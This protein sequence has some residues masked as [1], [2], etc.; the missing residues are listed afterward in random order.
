MSKKRTRQPDANEELVEGSTDSCDESSITGNKC[1][2]IAKAVN[3]NKIKRL[4]S[5]VG[6]TMECSDCKQNK[7]ISLQINEEEST[8]SS[9]T[10]IC[11]VCG[12]R[13]CK[14]EEYG[15]ALQHFKTPHSDC[16]C[17]VVNTRSWNVW[18]HDCEANIP[19]SHRNKLQETVE[20]IKQAIIVK[21]V[22]SQ[23]N[24]TLSYLW[25]GAV[26]TDVQ[27]EKALHN[28]PKVGGL[29]N[30]GNT[31][32]FNA[33][34]QCLAQTPFLVKVLSDL[35]LPG[36]KIVL[37]GGKHKP[38][39]S[40]EE[41]DITPIEGTLEGWGNFTSVLHATLVE[42]Q[43][44]DGQKCYC[45]SELLN[46]FKKKQMQCMDGGQHDSHELLRHLLELV[47]N[48]DLKRYQLVILKA[49]GLN[50]K[51][52][53]EEV[54]K[55]LKSCVKFYGNQ[56]SARLLGPEP[57]FCG[58]LVSTLECLD[59]H[60]TSQSTEPF[61]DLSLPVMADK[62]QPPIVKR[63]NSG[64][65]DAFDMLGNMISRASTKSQL[66]K[67]KKPA[68]KN[69]RSK[70]QESCDYSNDTS[71]KSNIIEENNGS[72]IEPEE[73]SDADVEDNAETEAFPPEVG[74]SGYSSEKQ[75]TLAS[76]AS[77][78][79]DPVKADETMNEMALDNSLQFSPIN[80]L[81]PNQ[82]FFKTNSLHSPHSTDMNIKDLSQVK[83]RDRLNNC[84]SPVNEAGMQSEYFMSSSLTVN[85][86]LT[87]PEGPSTVSLSSATS[88]ESSCSPTLAFKNASKN[89]MDNY[90][91][92][93]AHN[94]QENT[95]YNQRWGRRNAV[96]YSNEICN[97]VNGISSGISKMGLGC[98][99]SPI[100]Y[101][102]NEGEC[103]IMSCLN[104]FT[105]LE[106]MRGSNK[107]SCEACTARER[108]VKE[109][110]KMICTP[111]TKQYLISR[112]P[113]VLILHLKRFQ[114]QRIDF[115]KVTREVSFQTTLDL[116]PI[117]K[118]HKKPKLYSLYGVV[119]H[120]GTIH[121][122][123][124]VAYVK[125]RMPLAS[126]DPRWSF[127]PTNDTQETEENSESEDSASEDGVAAC[128]P[129]SVEPPP[130]K[131]YYVSD[132]KVTEVDE[133]TVR[134]SQAYLL[135]Y[136]RYY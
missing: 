25:E 136:E 108:K 74:E 59:C 68:R 2:H 73:E 115:R 134:R 128:P 42:M 101:P 94:E 47:R 33:V 66:K 82:D 70:R 34:L 119:E 95:A 43:N 96:E 52:N 29:M 8:G 81:P 109:N 22:S 18:C 7:S 135:F 91:E 113:A 37:P 121:G 61:L 41:F 105:A 76:P 26:N 89:V 60:H 48:E 31:C 114:A 93:T 9:T 77:P 20:L 16:H 23:T 98:Q 129:I 100:R 49:I 130:G 30:L 32:F 69:R 21:R 92:S 87:S 126:D 39:S 1:P 17:I 78:A 64:Y 4:I 3:Y 90:F 102:T 38:A 111:S 103:S 5:K 110:C 55:C 27:E 75:S 124:Y 86:D 36:Q 117:C 112:V 106:L 6:I 107:V 35:R 80:N 99:S 120:R 116:S 45:P 88:K 54:E 24:T 15:H 13:G 83:A 11:L 85:P 53:P 46:S 10:L 72:I 63:K 97:G 51:T 58:V 28:L 125:S 104:Q 12:H 71:N 40:S 79:T 19:I 118:N 62:P 84:D 56:A 122:G 65:E 67:E 57:V 131:W 133:D 14:V 127:L 50:E 44:S 123:H 132:S